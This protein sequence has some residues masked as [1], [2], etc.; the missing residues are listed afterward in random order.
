MAVQP[1]LRRPDTADTNASESSA[2]CKPKSPLARPMEKLQEVHSHSWYA[3]VIVLSPL[4]IAWI[5]GPDQAGLTDILANMMPSLSD[6]R[7]WGTDPYWLAVVAA[8]NL[9]RVSYTVLWFKADKFKEVVEKSPVLKKKHPVDWV[10]SGFKFFKLLQFGTAAWWYLTVAPRVIFADITHVR[11]AIA[12][13]WISLGQALNVGIYNA[14]G[15]DGVYYGFKLGRNVP[16][17]EGFPFTVIHHPQYMGAILTEW[18]IF[19]LL[20]TPAHIV[21]GWY[22]LAVMQSIFYIWTCWVEDQD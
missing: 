4:I 19:L 18:G 22:G 6:Y 20:A 10:Y 12:V 11:W 5:E 14:I 3:L 2:G 13:A 17:Y 15:K 21:A 7:R 16:W 9:E 8:M 1:T